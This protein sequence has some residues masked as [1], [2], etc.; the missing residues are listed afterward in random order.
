MRARTREKCT[1]QICPAIARRTVLGERYCESCAKSVEQA[2]YFA[3]LP[4]K[5]AETV[6]YRG[7]LVVTPPE[8][9]TIPEPLSVPA[10]TSW[11]SRR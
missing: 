7:A 3:A 6:R 2:A 1:V 8:G 4:P 11:R 10:R 9:V 5:A